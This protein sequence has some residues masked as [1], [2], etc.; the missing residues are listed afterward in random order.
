MEKIYN[1]SLLFITSFI[2]A[3]LLTLLS[4]SLI[5]KYV[6][7]KVEQY[8]LLKEHIEDNYQFEIEYEEI[9]K[10]YGKQI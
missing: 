1:I 7:S 2:M 10:H 8:M 3:T 5:D 6:E 4:Y 9:M